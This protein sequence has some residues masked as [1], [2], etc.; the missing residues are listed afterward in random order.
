MMGCCIN[1]MKCNEMKIMRVLCSV[2][3]CSLVALEKVVGGKLNSV[4]FN[5]HV[6]RTTS[7]YDHVASYL[8]DVVTN[9][10]RYSQNFGD[11]VFGKQSLTQLQDSYV[12]IFHDYGETEGKREMRV[13]ESQ[14]QLFQLV[15]SVVL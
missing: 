4:E 15:G 7:S 12:S 8:Y 5:H 3:W 11:V 10:K 13:T 14:H 9:F 6:L 2:L 1:E